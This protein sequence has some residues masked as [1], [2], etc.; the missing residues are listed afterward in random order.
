M[1]GWQAFLISAILLTLG[2]VVPSSGQAFA[3]AVPTWL[4]SVQGAETFSQGLAGAPERAAISRPDEAVGKP[5]SMLRRLPAGQQ[6]MRIE[7][8]QGTFE[9]AIFLT[10]R[11]AAAPARFHLSYLSALSILPEASKVVVAINGQAVGSRSISLPGRTD[12]VDLDIPAGLLVH[13]FNAVRISVDQ[14]HRADCSVGAT[15]ELWTLIDRSQT[16]IVFSDL[17]A[18][19][20]VERL[21]EL[22]ALAV[23]DDG[24][25]PIRIVLGGKM[26]RELTEQLIAA[27]ERIALLA[28]SQQPVVDFGA[29]LDGAEGINLV[30]GTRAELPALLDT[31]AAPDSMPGNLWFVPSRSGRRPTLVVTGTTPAELMQSLATLHSAVSPEKPPGSAAG[32]VAFAQ[33][34]GYRVSGSEERVPLG[35]LG[36]KEA[37]FSGRFYRFDFQLAMPADFLA[38]DYDRV[39]LDLFGSYGQGLTRD[40]QVVIEVN[41]SSVA[42]AMLP[43]SAGGVFELDQILFPLSRLR[44][45]VN[46]ISI[47]AQ[48][49]RAT[50]QACD[51]NVPAAGDMRFLLSDRSRIVL[52][53]I[54]RVGRV[55]DLALT[56]NSGVAA[57]TSDPSPTLYVPA[58]DP[59]S[60]SAALTLA[61]QLAVAQSRVIDFHFTVAP[62]TANDRNLL[63][64]APASRLDPAL[65]RMIGLDPDQIRT[66]WDEMA[67]T[68]PGPIQTSSNDAPIV[69][70]IKL[71]DGGDD[72]C[73]A[74]LRDGAAAGQRQLVAMAEDQTGSIP[75]AA[76]RDRESGSLIERLREM[77]V[78]WIGAE[79][80]RLLV[81]NHT[82]LVVAEGRN[83]DTSAEWTIVTA[84]S[85]L[86][87]QQSVE[88]M[89]APQRW[90]LLHGRQAMIDF[91]GKIRAIEARKVHYL[92]T[93]ALSFTNARL[94]FAA[95]LS[96]NSAVY[97]AAMLLLAGC[98]GCATSTLLS[99]VGRRQK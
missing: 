80:R 66:A 48:L 61:S 40:A 34:A 14:R 7:G 38:V 17:D 3:G 89:V 90:R 83:E 94:V 43:R 29:L 55:P 44:P 85:P 26:S 19:S 98:L 81:D 18:V 21:D 27:A 37:P 12:A 57:S 20:A 71:G 95:W 31:F 62:P 16:G 11:Q 4:W 86:L 82:L 15:Y 75:L 25:M 47:A 87:L 23:R 77:A 53:N 51:S 10:D 70:R 41:G 60:M 93:Q 69:R 99:N 42:T 64:V 78:S 5:A 58:P 74:R 30:V 54:A 59:Q 33:M 56:L 49:P 22:P 52:P 97:I 76:R 84:A 6:A 28:D 13:G 50:D 8:E 72:G 35:A 1:K 68:P 63:L 92:A 45:G 9:T 46:R 65:M 96:L 24:A 88:C 2:A 67:S 32:L 79:P 36:L 91:S 39:A 73:L